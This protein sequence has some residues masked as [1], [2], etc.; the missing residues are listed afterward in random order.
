[1]P[2]D[3]LKLDEFLP[4][5]LSRLADAVSREFSS[6]Y[7][8]KHGLTR[9]EWRTLATLGEFGGMTATAV[10]AHSAMHKTKV[11]RAVAALEKRRWLRRLTAEA[12]RRVEQLSLTTAGR[13]AYLGLV[14]VAKAFEARLLRSVPA[15]QRAQILQ[16]LIDLERAVAA[17]E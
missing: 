5:R 14:P 11:S 13:Q 10:G 8:A 9:P 2:A 15:Q 3:I 17:R 12:D 16:L 7:R 4:Y 1:M 6:L